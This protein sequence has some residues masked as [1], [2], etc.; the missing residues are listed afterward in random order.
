MLCEWSKRLEILTLDV[1]GGPLSE[2][3]DWFCAKKVR[4]PNSGRG[5]LRVNP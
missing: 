4:V 5:P 3:R 2:V 1:P